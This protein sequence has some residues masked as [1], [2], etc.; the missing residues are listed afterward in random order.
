[1]FFG[2]FFAILRVLAA[3]LAGANRM[4]FWRFFAFN[5]VGGALWA[6]VFGVGACLLGS[7]LDRLLGPIGVVSLIVAA[8]GLGA[9]AVVFRRHEARL[10]AEA[11]RVVPEAL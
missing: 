6:V 11:E 1:V 4:P 8:L 2:R 5:A 10:Q 3:L 9:M 7:Q